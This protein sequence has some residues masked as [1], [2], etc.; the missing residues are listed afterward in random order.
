VRWL[1]IAAMVVGSI[2]VASFVFS[3]VA[4][5]LFALVHEAGWWAMVAL[6]WPA[7]IGFFALRER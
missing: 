1:L 7:T 3:S 6:A 4:L 2:V 5:D